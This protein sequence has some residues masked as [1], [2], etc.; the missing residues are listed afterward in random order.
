MLVFQILKIPFAGDFSGLLRG[1]VGQV[2]F[3]NFGI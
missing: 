1:W 2:G 3:Q